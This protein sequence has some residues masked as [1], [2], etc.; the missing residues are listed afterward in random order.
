LIYWLI[1]WLIDWLVFSEKKY[2]RCK[3]CVISYN[4]YGFALK[5]CS[6]RPCQKFALEVV[7]ILFRFVSYLRMCSTRF[8][9]YRWS[10]YRLRVIRRVSLVER[11]LPTLPEHLSSHP[12][13]SGVCIAQS[14]VFCVV[15]CRSLFVLLA[16]VLSF[17]LLG[18]WLPLWDFQTVFIQVFRITPRKSV[19]YLLH[20]KQWHLKQTK[21][22]V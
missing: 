8:P 5:R 11:I 21:S 20:R 12:V 1:D 6:V 18:F 14:L 17:L 9:D 2:Q 13:L 16:I 15:F 3:P 4:F 7:H 19:R 22:D 10:S